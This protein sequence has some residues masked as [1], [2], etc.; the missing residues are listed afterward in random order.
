MVAVADGVRG[1]LQRPAETVGPAVERSVDRVSD[2]VGDAA[3][4][5]VGGGAGEIDDEDGVA[6]D[7]VHLE[8]GEEAELAKGRAEDVGGEHGVEAHAE[9]AGGG[10]GARGEEAEGLRDDGHG[11]EGDGAEED[12]GVGD[13][14]VVVGVGDGLAVFD[15]EVGWF[16]AFDPAGHACLLVSGVEKKS[17][18]GGVCMYV[19]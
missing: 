2:R 6:E 4:P 16:E 1:N 18:G 15:V 3:E 13:G 10:G 9:R 8:V 7:R 12:G 14:A 19:E 11:T 17:R 5:E